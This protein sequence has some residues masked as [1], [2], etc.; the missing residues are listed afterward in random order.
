[1]QALQHQPSTK[2]ASKIKT[3][4]KEV[5]KKYFDKNEILKK[6]KNEK[7][8]KEAFFRGKKNVILPRLDLLFLFFLF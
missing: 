3:N 5:K 2:F 8:F 7:L 4:R 6:N 1:M